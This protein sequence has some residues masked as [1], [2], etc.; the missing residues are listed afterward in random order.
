MP[1]GDALQVLQQG[2]VLRGT[3]E[4]PDYLITWK[5]KF[6]GHKTLTVELDELSLDEPIPYELT[7]EA[8]SYLDGFHPG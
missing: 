6:D 2:K 3:I 5:M 8:D 1:L 7:E 4:V